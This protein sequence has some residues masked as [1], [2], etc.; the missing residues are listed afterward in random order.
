MAMMALYP[1]HE[2][3]C[4]KDQQVKI[5]RLSIQECKIG[6][7]DMTHNPTWTKDHLDKYPHHVWWR[8]K[9]TCELLF[10]PKWPVYEL[11]INT[12]ETNIFIKFD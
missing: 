1:S 12:I 6:Y 9:Q 10:E 4:T 8:S 11:D 2:F 3:R 5:W 7:L